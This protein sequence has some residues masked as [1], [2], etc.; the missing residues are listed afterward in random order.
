MYNFS[1]MRREIIL[2]FFACVSLTLNQE[3]DR[4]DRFEHFEAFGEDL[5]ISQSMGF[6]HEIVRSRVEE[7]AGLDRD[8]KVSFHG[9]SFRE[10]I[11]KHASFCN[12]MV[13]IVKIQNISFVGCDLSRYSDT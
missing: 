2:I 5:S 9:I 8:C 13:Q 12:E 4:I 6:D 7:I 11:Q 10:E 1:S 3:D